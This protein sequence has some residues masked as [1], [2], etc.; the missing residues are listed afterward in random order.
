MSLV[1]VTKISSLILAFVAD[2]AGLSL[3][4]SETP[5]DTFSYD[6]AHVYMY[7][8]CLVSLLRLGIK[9]DLVFYY[10]VYNAFDMW[11]Y[12]KPLLTYYKQTI[13]LY[14]TKDYIF[15][16]YYWLSKASQ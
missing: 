1:S 5:E 11:H 8:Q 10:V 7:I 2:Q 16:S 15:S 14:F 13:I 6:E 4:R 3:T 9:Y 12:N